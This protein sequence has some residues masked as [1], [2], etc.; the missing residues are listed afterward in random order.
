MTADLGTTG[1]FLSPNAYVAS[2]RISP[3]SIRVSV[4][5][6]E[7]VASNIMTNLNLK[8]LPE[9]TTL[10]CIMPRFPD[11]LFS[12]KNLCD[13]GLHCT[14]TSTSVFAFD[15][16][17]NRIKLQGWRDK[18]SGLWRFPI[19]NV[20]LHQ[21]R[22]IESIPHR[23]LLANNA[24]DLPSIPALIK[25]HHAAARFP[26]KQSWLAAIERGNYATWPGLTVQAVRKHCPEAAETTYGTMS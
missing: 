11:N 14:F 2:K 18:N 5:N 15:S 17:T 13:L 21:S 1:H 25:H 4:A 20:K 12:I 6:G 22:T 9:E 19:C 16:S 10:A 26:V 3:T 23:I 8:D 24:H 7:L